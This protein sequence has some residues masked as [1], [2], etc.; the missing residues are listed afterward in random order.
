MK[1]TNSKL[2]VRQMV[3]DKAYTLINILGL[4][5][6]ITC[7]LIIFLYVHDELTFDSNYANKD[8]IYRLNGGWRSMTDGSSNMYPRVGYFIGDYLKK[9]FPEVDQMVRLGRSWVTVEKTG[10]S[11]HFAEVFHKADSNVFNVLTFPIISGYSKNLL[12]DDNSVVITR[13]MA[14]K[15][16]NREDVVGETLHINTADTFDLKVTGVMEDYPDNTHLK[17]DF[18][19]RLK[20]PTHP[21]ANEWFEYGYYTFFTLKPNTNINSVESRIRYFTKPYV[22]EYE[23]E[24]GFVQE[25]SIIP[26][27]RIHLYSDLAGESNSKAAYVYIFLVIGIFILAMACINF[28]NLATA[29]SIKRAREIGIRKVIGALKI[30]L[31]GQ[32]LSEALV[33]NILAGIISVFG[34]YLLLPIVNGYSGKNM[35]IFNNPLFWFVVVGI[36][37][38]VTLMAGSYPSF[39]LSGFKPS[40]ILKGNFRSSNQGSV[41]RKALVVFQFVISVSLI[42]GTLIIMDHVRYLRQKELGFDKEHVLLIRGATQAT[43]DQLLNISG[44]SNASFS[45]IVPGNRIGGRTIINGWDKA[46]PQVVMGQLVVDY[47]YLA[48]YNLQLAAGRAFYKDVPSDMAEGFMINEAALGLLGYHNAEAAIGKELWLDED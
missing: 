19:V 15:Y 25:H 8:S 47:D 46:D 18:M 13:K 16:F 7:S 9:D 45:N 17:I 36:I 23:Q 35:E 43:K 40:E 28:M 31:V 22:A 39:V 5:L 11:E 41:L 10:T 3:R 2:M 26:F 12:P 24:I 1:L 42:A 4:T 48:L 21:V 38:M 32:F 37:G 44:V 34:V 20:A 27:S 6:G 29:R 30:Q 33:M 14:L